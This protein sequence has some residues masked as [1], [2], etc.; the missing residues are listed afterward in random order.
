VSRVSHAGLV[1]GSV[2]AEC[3]E[4]VRLKQSVSQSII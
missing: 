3:V 4:Q 2:M 1:C